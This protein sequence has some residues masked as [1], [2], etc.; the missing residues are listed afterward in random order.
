M[1]SEDKTYILRKP[2]KILETTK[3]PGTSWH[4]IDIENITTH[5]HRPVLTT[6]LL[7][8]QFV[9]FDEV[10]IR[11]QIAEIIYGCVEDGSDGGQIDDAVEDI[12]D[13]T[14]GR[15]Q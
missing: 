15:K 9:E 3:F 7:N 13:V 14:L 2:I 6:E 11:K 4:Q 1:G 5:N 12:L 8:H 10:A